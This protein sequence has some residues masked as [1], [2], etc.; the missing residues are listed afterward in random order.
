M[1]GTIFPI[2]CHDG[3]RRALVGSRGSLRRRRSGK[4]GRAIREPE[5]ADRPEPELASAHCNSRPTNRRTCSK[6][7][8]MPGSSVV[9][10]PPRSNRL[11]APTDLPWIHGLLSSVSGVKSRPERRYRR[12]RCARCTGDENAPSQ[13]FSRQRG[14]RRDR[15]NRVRPRISKKIFSAHWRP[16]AA[17]GR[18]QAAFG[19]DAR[20]NRCVAGG[21]RQRGQD[22]AGERVFPGDE[23][24]RSYR[25][26]I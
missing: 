10:M 19:A 17:S 2:N 23:A 5:C 24:R 4:S 8:R 20:V 1:T 14:S 16:A 11:I 22:G 25:V 12:E 13:R 21:P 18:A 3:A 7:H 26:L 9:P 15:A 6:Y